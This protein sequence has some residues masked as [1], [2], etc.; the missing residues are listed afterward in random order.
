LSNDF[1]IIVIGAGIAGLSAALTAARLAR[2][3]LVL[4]GEVL[5]GQLLNIEKIDGYPGFPEGVPGYDLCPIAQEQAAAAGAE[6]A[7]AGATRIERG[8]DGWIVSTA[9]DRYTARSIVLATGAR[10]RT[11]GVRGESTLRGKG[12]S[13]CASCDAP[14]LRNRPVVVAG[15][16][17]SALQEALTLAQHCSSVTIVHRG[18]EVVAQAAYRQLVEDHAKISFIA[19]AEVAEIVGADAVTGARIVQRAT[20][21]EREIACDAV[22]VFIGL[23]PDTSLIKD[24][25]G[26]PSPG[27]SHSSDSSDSSDSLLDDAGYVVTD[28]AMRTRLS[29]LL[30]AGT[31]RAGNACRA[32]A[33]AGDGATAA[34]EAD[35]FLREGRWPS[36]E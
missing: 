31:V 23:E 2:R 22:F 36:S 15:G 4:T 1:E 20:G 12:V 21:D 24:L 9:S 30:A 35:R 8:G 25:S 18:P 27:S 10:L 17:D 16:G 3:T 5:G 19:D 29:G 28:I 14:L 7:M 13:Q 32:A 11:L 26:R 33:A 6:F 34:L